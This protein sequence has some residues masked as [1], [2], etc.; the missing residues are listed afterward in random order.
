VES[1]TRPRNP[2]ASIGGSTGRKPFPTGL[3][4]IVCALLLAAGVLTRIYV[5]SRRSAQL[6]TAFLAWTTQLAKDNPSLVF[7]GFTASQHADLR[8]TSLDYHWKY[9]TPTGR[10]IAIDLSLQERPFSLPSPIVI[11]T[12]GRSMTLPLEDMERGRKL[13]LKTEFPEAF[14]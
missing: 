3:L 9:A 4:L 14:R 13:D 8:G 2:S 11:S 12:D 10:Q 7:R 1:E 5:T 6:Q